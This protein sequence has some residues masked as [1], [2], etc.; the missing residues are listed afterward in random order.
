[1][2]LLWLECRTVIVIAE[3]F[4]ENGRGLYHATTTGLC[5]VVRIVT[6]GP[7]LRAVLRM[8]Q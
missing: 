4:G 3:D 6:A 5:E 7:V 2:G 1:M 8:S